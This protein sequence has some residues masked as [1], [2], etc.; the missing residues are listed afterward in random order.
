M[1]LDAVRPLCL[2]SPSSGGSQLDTSPTEVDPTQDAITA[3]GLFVN[4]PTIKGAVD[5]TVLVDRI[6]GS[7]R[8]TDQAVSRVLGELVSASAGQTTSHAGLFDIIHFLTDGPG[9]GWP[10]GVYC[11][12]QYNGLLLTR[13]T[14][15][16]SSAMTTPIVQRTYTYN[17][18]L[19]A[20]DTVTLY[21][22]AGTAV[23]VCQD[24]YSYAGIQ[25]TGRTRTF[26]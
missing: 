2:E 19:V 4:G 3:A 22:A 21:S 1:A 13:A 6:N 7:L 26:S 8:F 18:L 17:G 20:T 14:W 24:V 5:K 11:Q 16:T 9:D 12:E 23:R 15:Y 10:S 25:R